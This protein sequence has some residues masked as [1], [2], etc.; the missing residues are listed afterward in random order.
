MLTTSSLVSNILLGVAAAITVFGVE[1]GVAHASDPVCGSGFAQ[2]IGGG[3]V[4]VDECA[5]GIDS[6]DASEICV[7]RQGT[8]TCGCDEGFA[9]AVG[10]GCVDMDECAMG[11]DDC[12]DDEICVNRQGTFTC[13]AAPPSSKRS[14]KSAP[15][16]RGGRLAIARAA[17]TEDGGEDAEDDGDDEGMLC[18]AAG[19]GA[20]P[21]AIAMILGVGAVL[22]GRRRKA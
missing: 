4:D 6:C 16:P 22:V 20:D 19:G 2:A 3:C 15:A 14:I 8:Y 21:S 7:N 9:E 17:L 1:L 18:S 13:S 12:D 10:G 11:T 5:M